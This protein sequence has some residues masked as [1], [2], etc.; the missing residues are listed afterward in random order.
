VPAPRPSRKPDQALEPSA[1]VSG[2]RRRGE[3][4]QAILDSAGEL[5]AERGYQGASIRDIAAH[6]EVNETLVF[7][8][9][10]TKDALFEEAIAAP[11]RAFLEDFAARW[12]QREDSLSNDEMLELFVLELHAFVVEHRDL[13]FALVV[14]NRFGSRETPAHAVLADAIRRVSEPAIAEAEWRQLAG[15][16]IEIGVT[17]T[18]ALVLGLV[19]LDDAL[20]PSGA[21]HPEPERLLRTLLAYTIAGAQAPVDATNAV[22]RSGGR[23]RGSGKRS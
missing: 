2:R 7:R 4:R 6:A 18:V 19:L 14:A 15:V 17:C 20:L 1:P 11:F 12:E 9:F 22:R 21:S 13:L 10:G 23:R 16:D 5:F 8:N 3:A